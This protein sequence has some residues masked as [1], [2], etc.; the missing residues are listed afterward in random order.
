MYSKHWRHPCHVLVFAL[1]QPSLLS[2]VLNFKSIPLVVISIFTFTV[3]GQQ[4]AWSHTTTLAN[5][6][7]YW[8]ASYYIGP[9]HS[10]LA[11]V[12][13]Y[14]PKAIVALKDTFIK[15]SLLCSC[16]PL[17]ATSV[18][19]GPFSGEA[20]S[21]S[22]VLVATSTLRGMGWTPVICASVSGL[23]ETI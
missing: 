15:V 23:V 5:V 19:P 6:I 22:P 14:W 21:K 1:W 16:A 3:F 17:P 12:I 8:P 20:P 18:L 11:S 7:L 10:I 13:L 9:R 2:F 4:E